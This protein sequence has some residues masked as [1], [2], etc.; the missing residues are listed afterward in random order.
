[1]PNRRRPSD[2]PPLEITRFTPDTAEQAI[3]LLGA[4]IGEVKA[5]DPKQVPY[6]DERVRATERKIRGTVLEVFGERSREYRDHQYHD[7]SGGRAVSVIGWDEDPRHHDTERQEDFAE[8]IHRTVTMLE[9]LIETVRERTD[10]ARGSRMVVD[11]PEQGAL[12]ASDEVFI[13]HGRAEGRGGIREWPLCCP[14]CRLRSDAVED[15]RLVDIQPLLSERR[16]ADLLRL[17]RFPVSHGAG[18]RRA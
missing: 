10:S 1:M 12:A 4:R 3:R 5:L 8:G 14:L 11:Q 16:P 18:A 2:P 6:N 15:R 17:G 9:S 13:V 7:I